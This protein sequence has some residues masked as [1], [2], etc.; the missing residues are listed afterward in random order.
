MRNILFI[1]IIFILAMCI[2][3]QNSGVYEIYSNDQKI[4][5]CKFEMK[6]HP[7]GFFMKSTTSMTVAGTQTTYDAETYYDPGY[8]PTSYSVDITTPSGTQQINGKFN[9]GKVTI[10]GSAG[11]K[12]TEESFAF[13]SNGYIIDQNIFSH[14]WAL[15]FVIN[16]KVGNIK[17]NIVIPQLMNAVQL[18]MVNEREKEYE[19][20]IATYFRGTLGESEI[21]MWITHKDNRIVYV[22]YPNQKLSVKLAE[23]KSLE[24]ESARLNEG[25]NPITNTE[26]SDKDFMEMILD[27]KKFKARISFNPN[28]RLDRI[29]LNR[30][31]QAFAGSVEQN[32]VSGDVE[33]RRLSHRVTL[34]G[35]WPP[36]EPLVTDPIFMSPAPGIDSDDQSIKERAEAIVEPAR[37]IWDAA[38]AINLWVNRN[39]TYDMVRYTS[40]DA[41]VKGRGDSHTKA[42]VATAMLRSVGIP[43]RVIRGILYV[44]V[45]LDHSWVEVFLGPELGWAPIDP[46]TDEVDEI[47]ARHIS[48]WVGEEQP[49]VF[50]KDIKIEPIE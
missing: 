9:R 29:Y 33:L 10:K 2:W 5:Q 28:G 46:T 41:I 30:R 22:G 27:S 16:P 26:L 6:K 13:P 1:G 14:F 50:A 40:K 24:E 42:L 39:I 7:M 44:D 11:V 36:I 3:A 38:R 19:G 37:T 17:Y 31:A 45:P 25:Y 34:A 47:S 4:G 35:E 32:L 21:E 15:N 49:P 48:L 8:H 12:Q 23:V 18:S 43:A 20:K